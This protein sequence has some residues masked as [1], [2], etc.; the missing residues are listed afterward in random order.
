MVIKLLTII[1][2]SSYININYCRKILYHA[3]RY[4]L[5]LFLH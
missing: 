4:L 1:L 2:F 3:V 5:L